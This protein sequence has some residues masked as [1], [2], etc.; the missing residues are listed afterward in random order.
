MELRQVWFFVTK[1]V[2]LVLVTTVLAA[3]VSF[4]ISRET[5]P[6]YGASATVL[7]N[8]AQNPATPDYNSVLTSE[9]LTQT[10]S[11]LI[12]T[13]PVLERTI[14]DLR[15]AT[16]PDELDR[17]V[18]V[19]VIPNTTLIQVTAEDPSP[20]LSQDLANTLATEFINA[21]QSQRADATADSRTALKQQITDVENAI[22]TS[23]TQL[24]QLKQQGNGE[25]AEALQTQAL[26][27]QQ[28][29]S[30]SQLLKTQ[31]DMQLADARA[32]DSLS[33]VEPAELPIQPVRPRVLLNVLLA[34]VLGLLAG[35]AA[36]YLL[37]YL[38]DTIKTPEDAQEIGNLTTLGMVLRQSPKDGRAPLVVDG[39]SRSPV[40]ESY[41]ILRTNI[42]FARVSQPA[43]I[44]VVTSANPGDG[45]TTTLANLSIV[46]AESGKRVLAVDSDLR[47][48]TLHN[49]F[50]LPNTRGL[51]NL[52]LDPE[53]S[54]SSIVL[55]TRVP[56]LS[57][58]P[59]G[60]IPPNPSELVGSDRMAHILDQ[61]G[62]MADIVL[63]DSPPVLAVTDP[64]VLSARADGVVLIV[65]TS[66]TR[67]EV[68]KRAHQTLT[69]GSARILG[70]VLNRITSS[71]G[72]YYYY[73]YREGYGS[74]AGSSNGSIGK[75]GDSA[76]GVGHR[77]HRRSRTSE[78]LVS[79]LRRVVARR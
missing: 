10:Y 58:I 9:R 70:V 55:P 18:T 5:T 32:T 66:T 71:H 14:Q 16:T 39:P 11:Q 43:R 23:T 50:G 27:T 42:E 78:G 68:L 67:R 24:N 34:A 47:R 28:Q 1:W 72:G 40:A 4:V 37:E 45:K 7:I 35:G 17:K 8:Q 69:H 49:L 38:D 46:M 31:S 30:Y 73:Y 41:R 36:A 63:L 51:T 74:D 22:K 33:I 76:N 61:L 25:S 65:D 60:P 57:V 54:P 52:L 77:S 2:W 12:K 26:L 3:A 48:P 13:R 44:I 79:S 20:K 53:L 59:S 15:L 62:E 19:S 75:P 21:V 29:A 56:N 6:V 64:A